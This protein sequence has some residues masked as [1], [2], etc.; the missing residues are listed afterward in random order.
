MCSLTIKASFFNR[1]GYRYPLILKTISDQQDNLIYGCNV[2]KFKG[3]YNN[4]LEERWQSNMVAKF[5]PWHMSDTIRN[6]RATHLKEFLI[7]YNNNVGIIYIT[8]TSWKRGNEL[9]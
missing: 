4:G 5:T 7:T 9:C 3:K 6:M 2:N 8:L 1:K